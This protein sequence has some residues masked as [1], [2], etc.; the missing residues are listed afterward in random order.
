ME[1]STYAMEELLP[2]VA[3]LTEKYTSKES[4]SVTFETARKLMDA[5]IYC[6]REYEDLDRERSRDSLLPAEGSVSAKEAYE[7][8]FILVV[9]K[10]KSVQ[11]QYNGMILDFCGYGNEN[12]E[13]T[14]KKGISGF[15]RKYDARFAPQETIITLDYPTMLSV[16]EWRG[17]DTIER[18]LEYIVLEQKFLGALEDTYVYRVLAAYQQDYT[19]QFY[20]ICLIIL[21][22]ILGDML[23]GKRPGSATEKR[24]YQ[25][26][27]V[28]IKMVRKE[29]LED[30]MNEALER[31]IEMKYGADGELFRY[32][33]ADQKDFLVEL[34]HAAEH[35]CL[36][37]VVVL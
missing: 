11:Q 16:R 30:K 9:N 13:D 19:K 17:I 21:R 27:K 12:Y 37:R 6:I 34:E 22:S 10:V 29:E 28:M 31:L 1:K 33:R 25:K 36:D 15:F 14:V 2:V 5:V 32:L 24:D 26:L 23:I 8:G 35:N 3:E 18:Y 4:T 20:N 7:L